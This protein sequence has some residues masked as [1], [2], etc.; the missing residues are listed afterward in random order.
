MPLTSLLE[1]DN[2]TSAQ[3]NTAIPARSQWTVSGAVGPTNME[4][5]E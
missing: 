3:A 1:S 4:R 2:W 5:P